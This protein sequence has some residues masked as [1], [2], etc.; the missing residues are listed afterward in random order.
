MTELMPEFTIAEKLDLYDKVMLKYVRKHKPS[1]VTKLHWWPLDFS[2]GCERIRILNEI[3]HA[4]KKEK[5]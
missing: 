3:K 2:G 4:I 1:Y 5:G